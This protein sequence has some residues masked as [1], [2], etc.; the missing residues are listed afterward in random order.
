MGRASRKNYC[1]TELAWGR[2]HLG[3][4]FLLIYFYPL[5]KQRT[6]EVRAILDHRKAMREDIQPKAVPE[7]EN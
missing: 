4:A 6:Y 5:T 1:K 2:P 7:S 3:I